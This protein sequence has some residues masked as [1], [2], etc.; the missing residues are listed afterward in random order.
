MPA[1]FLIPISTA[2]VI[3][4][5]QRELLG[6]VVGSVMNSVSVRRAVGVWVWVLTR[7]SAHR[8]RCHRVALFVHTHVLYH[9]SMAQFTRWCAYCAPFVTLSTFLCALEFEDFAGE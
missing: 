1:P 5:A 9:S 8:D 3:I 6:A 2:G 7:R 4:Y